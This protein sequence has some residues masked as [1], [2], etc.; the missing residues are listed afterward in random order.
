MRLG[1]ETEA[2]TGIREP[3]RLLRRWTGI[4]R[5]RGKVMGDTASNVGA[6]TCPRMALMRSGSDTDPAMGQYVGD[7]KRRRVEKPTT[8]WSLRAV[9]PE[10][11]YARGQGGATSCVDAGERGPRARARGQGSLGPRPPANRD[12]PALPQG[13]EEGGL[14]ARQLRKPESTLHLPLSYLCAFFHLCSSP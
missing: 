1:C 5:K 9:P 2:N 11:R 14:R 6:K 12:L 10:R 7:V 4:T 8:P 3:C 13:E